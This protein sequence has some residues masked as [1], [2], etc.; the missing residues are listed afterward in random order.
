GATVGLLA[1][2][3][4]TYH[5]DAQLLTQRNTVMPALGNPGR[6]VPTDANVP[7]RAAAE[8]VLRRDNLLSLMKQTD[9][10]NRWEQKRTPVLR[11]KD[12]L[13]QQIAPPSE[14]DRINAMVGFLEKR[15]S[16]TTGESTVTIGIDWPDAQM[17]YALVDNALQNFLEQR[18][19]AEVSSIAE[20]ISILESHATDLREQ[21]D[22]TLEDIKRGQAP[23]SKPVKVDP[24][25]PPPPRRDPAVEAARAQ[26]AE[27]K[28]MIEAKRRAINELDDFRR[29]RLAELQTELAQKRAVYADA[30]PAV[31]QILQSISA[32]QEDSPQLAALRK[33][34]RDLQ[35]EY[36][37]LAAKRGEGGGSGLPRSSEVAPRRKPGDPPEAN[38]EGEYSRTRLRFAMEKYDVL[39]DRINSARIELDTARAAFKYRYSIVRPPQLPK[40]PEKPKVPLVLAAGVMA[41]IAFSIVAAALA[42]LRSGRVLESWQVE[43]GLGLEVLGEVPR[44]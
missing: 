35:T 38:V 21:I 31:A 43:R 8:T 39:L 5:V 12:W 18:H 6:T 22:S 24:A 19:S 27:V 33:D 7:T 9:L 44:P 13:V 1:I 30:H 23:V 36:E 17:G 37:R 10:L 41:A 28:V 26:A 11:L 42:D 20:T 32:L 40:R 2:L 4:R 14:E 16:V 25:L 15:F 29:R 34:E 3:P